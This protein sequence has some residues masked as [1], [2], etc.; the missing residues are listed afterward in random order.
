[1]FLEMAYQN[2]ERLA[3][4]VDDI[5]DL[6]K[7]ESGKLDLALERVEL[8]PFLERALALNAAYADRHETRFELEATAPGIFVRADPDRLLQVLTNLLSNAA[9]FSPPGEPVRVSARVEGPVVRV[10]VIDRGPGVPPE[11]RTRIFMKF[12]QAQS[13]SPKGGT[14]LGLAISKAIVEAMHGRIGYDDDA[15]AGATFYFELP[16]AGEGADSDTAA[17]AERRKRDRRRVPR[18]R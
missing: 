4:L 2:G 10:E 17:V 16:L 13:A 9:K 1:M 5:L 14:G 3:A 12:A 18:D 8:A 6:E 7:V 15:P 11:F